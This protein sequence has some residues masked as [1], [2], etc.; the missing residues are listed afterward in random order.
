MW[1]EPFA[2]L[3]RMRKRFEK[4]FEEMPS[5]N[6]LRQPL[7]DIKVEPNSIKVFIELPGVDKKDIEIN[8]KDNE[9]EVKSESKAKKESE[10]KG[11]YRY[12]RSYSGFYR[13]LPLPV[14]VIPDKTSAEFK[15][16]V[17]TVTLARAEP[18]K[19]K[20]PAKI[21]IK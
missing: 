1:W 13:L 20:K 18:K 10:H 14:P 15:D 2:E 6:G 4:F 11:Y 3:D 9:L 16:G 12:E 21:I 19:E 8:V 5:S 17:L 7:T